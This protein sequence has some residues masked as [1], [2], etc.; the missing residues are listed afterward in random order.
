[1]CVCARMRA[2]VC[3]RDSERVVADTDA[4]SSNA[5]PGR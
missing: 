4:D 3:V 2:C 1:M 5:Y